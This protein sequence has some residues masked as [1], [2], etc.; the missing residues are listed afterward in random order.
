MKIILFSSPTV[1]PDFDFIAT[2]PNLGIASIAGNINDICSV[3]VADVH[4]LK[5][6][7]H[8]AFLESAVRKHRP[9][10]IGLSCMSFQYHDALAMAKKAKEMDVMTVMGGYHPTL[11]YREIAQTAD[12]VY[13]DFMV[14]GE[15][16]ATFRELVKS[17][18]GGQFDAIDG[19]SYRDGDTYVHNPPRGLLNLDSVRLPD[20]E[21][22]LITKGFRA[23]GRPIDGIETSRGCVQGCKFCSIHHM[24]GQTFRTYEIERVIQDIGKAEA[25]GAR[26]ILFTDDNITL[27]PRRLMGLCDAI[28]ENGLDHLHY[29]TQASARGIAYSPEVA[30][31]MAKAGFTFTFLG[32]ENV[33]TRNLEF[34]N[35]GN[36]S[37]DAEVAVRNLRAHNIIVSGGLI[38]GTPDDTREDMWNNFR[39]ARDMKIDVPIFYIATPYPKTEL[40]QEMIDSGLVTNT[41]DFTRYDGL[42]ANIRTKHMSDREIQFETWKMAAR[43]YDRYWKNYTTIPRIYPA[44]F[45][46]KAAILSLKYVRRKLLRFLGLK[47]TEDF[48]DEDC[49]AR[50][51]NMSVY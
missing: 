51:Y 35:K 15:G 8:M 43:F 17:L 41:D 16:E 1:Q 38:M 11:M 14:R 49:K 47:K 46:K 18:D 22:R 37:N 3:H 26:S 6:K 44:W 29:L 30:R 33:L 45:A 28:V 9:D 36:M 32:I 27:N 42:T 50:T 4:A 39:A 12:S 31:S 7:N 19:L 21:S 40:R 34:F 20:R 23:F 5:K 24:Y 2:V 13:I 25:A 10:M 48:F